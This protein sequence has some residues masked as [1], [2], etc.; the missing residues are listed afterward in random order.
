ML[1]N[2]R[3]GSLITEFLLELCGA[4][5]IGEEER[6]ESDPVLLLEMLNLGTV[7]ERQIEIHKGGA[8][9]RSKRN[10]PQITSETKT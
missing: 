3:Y 2:Q 4:D 5:Q 1:L 8:D 9:D 7:L 6:Q 10:V